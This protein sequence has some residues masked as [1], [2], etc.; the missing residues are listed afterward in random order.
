[1]KAKTILLW[2]GLSLMGG[3]LSSQAIQLKRL[4]SSNVHGLDLQALIDGDL[5]T[6]WEGELHPWSNSHWVEL[7]WEEPIDIGQV[8]IST[9]SPTELEL[10]L[11]HQSIHRIQPNQPYAL[12]TKAKQLLIRSPRTDFFDGFSIGS[13]VLPAPTT[14]ISISEIFIWGEGQP[15]PWILSTMPEVPGRVFSSSVEE[16]ATLFHPAFLFDGRPEFGWG[17]DHGT[18]GAGESVAFAFD[19]SVRIDNI[20]IRDGRALAWAGE[21]GIRVERVSMQVGDNKPVVLNLQKDPIGGGWKRGGGG[22]GMEGNLFILKIEGTTHPRPDSELMNILELEFFDG[23]QWFR[24]KPE[25]ESEQRAFVYSKTEKTTIG[26]ILDEPFTFK[27]GIHQTTICFYSRGDVTI[28]MDS[29]PDMA[30]NWHFVGGWE[31][32]P[33][34][35]EVSVVKVS[36]LLYNLEKAGAQLPEATTDTF[37]IIGGTINGKRLIHAG[38]LGTQEGNLVPCALDNPIGSDLRYKTPENFMGKPLYPECMPCLVRKETAQALAQAQN[39][40]D[41]RCPGKN[42][43]LLIWDAYRPLEVQKQMWA[44]VP[45]SQYVAN[46]YQ[47][48]SFHNKGYAVDLT[49]VDSGGKPLKMGTGFDFFGEK[50][51]H[52]YAK[53]PNKVKKNRILLKSVM[54]SAGFEALP[55]EWWHYRL[56]G[57]GGI[58]DLK[59]SCP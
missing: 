48:G 49:I 21:D 39:I 7:T 50:A 45:D 47:G 11:D 41:L 13:F 17:T 40:L 38:L 46:P 28:D 35:G 25:Q 8:Q 52:G 10:I 24:M 16:P 31:N 5:K 42:H 54:E 53:L 32:L 22:L 58:I 29:I 19:Q 3:N 55:T 33:P 34:E 20:R 4:N 1:M 6:I 23:E 14:R 44:E 26:T 2:V 18:Y 30:G 37:R 57:N 12:N 59:V 27:E 15:Q 9:T 51:H 56:P 36:G 43:R